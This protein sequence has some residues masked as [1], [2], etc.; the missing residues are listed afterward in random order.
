MACKDNVKSVKQ[1]SETQG[2]EETQEL[3]LQGQKERFCI[4]NTEPS[5]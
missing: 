4:A 2:Q 5:I 3:G 1:W